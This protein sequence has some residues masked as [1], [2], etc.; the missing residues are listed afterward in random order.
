MTE[1]TI[2][3]TAKELCASYYEEWHSD[4]FRKLWPNVGTYVA[5]NWPTWVPI[6][7]TKLTEMLG[8]KDSEVSPAMK[9]A[10]YAALIEDRE[11][12]GRQRSTQVGRGPMILRP[13]QPGKREQAIFYDKD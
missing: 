3:M 5:R 10:I 6:A 2:R 13:D 4:R 8:K 12:E 1:R 11:R 9:E 7:R